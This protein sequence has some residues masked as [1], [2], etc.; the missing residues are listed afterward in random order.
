MASVPGWT[1]SKYPAERKALSLVEIASFPAKINMKIIFKLFM[2]TFLPAIILATFFQSGVYSQVA[3]DMGLRPFIPGERDTIINGSLVRIINPR[4]LTTGFSLR[5][6]DST[7]KILGFRMTFDHGNK[8]SE[9]ILNG[10]RIEPRN[11]SIVSLNRIV[12]SV[13][14]TIEDI[15]VS[16]NGRRAKL[17]A[18][19]YYSCK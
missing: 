7:F 11:D 12:E 17:P 6:T 16:K 1:F 9:L 18:L 10:D 15:Y 5:M 8:I 19:L 3:K 13:L 14:I 2:K 4:D